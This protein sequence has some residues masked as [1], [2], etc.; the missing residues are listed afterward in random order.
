MKAVGDI[1]DRPGKGKW[2]PSRKQKD[3]EEG[4]KIPVLNAV[5]STANVFLYPPISGS[6]KCRYQGVAVSD[7]TDRFVRGCP[8]LACF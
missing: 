8:P 1:G 5:G 2:H 7:V 3:K 6:W 4:R